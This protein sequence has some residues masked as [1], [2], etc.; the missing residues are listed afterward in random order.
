MG[1]SHARSDHAPRAESRPT[2]EEMTA[3]GPG[4]CGSIIPVPVQEASQMGST[5]SRCYG[6]NHEGMSS[7]GTC[8][9]VKRK[10]GQSA[11]PRS[12]PH[13]THARAHTHAHTL[14]SS[15]SSEL[16]A[17]VGK[18]CRSVCVTR[19]AISSM[20]AAVVSS[21]SCS[22]G[23]GLGANEIVMSKSS[24]KA[25]AAAGRRAHVH[26][27]TYSVNKGRNLSRWNRDS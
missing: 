8:V 21:S 16:Q 27:V 2:D 18:W 4:F 9:N 22:A 6:N 19:A 20:S 15:E 7:K 23:G 12:T 5:P 11:R 14:T 13:N 3:Y 1:A 17:M 10:Q 26:V 25:A 24:F